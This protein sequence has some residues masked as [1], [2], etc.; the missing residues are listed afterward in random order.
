[1]SSYIQIPFGYRKKSNPLQFTSPKFNYENKL[2][3][4]VGYIK[5]VDDPKIKNNLLNA[6]KSRED[7]QKYILANSDVG[8]D[9]QEDINAITS[10]DEKFNNAAVRRALDLKNNDLFRNPQPITLL[11]HD[12]ER[13]HQ[14]NPI[15]GKLATQINVPKLSNRDEIRKKLLEGDIRQIE[16][17]L[18]NLRNDNNTNNF[19]IGGDNNNN[20]GGVNRGGDDDSDDSDGDDPPPPASG[21]RIGAL[22]EKI[23]VVDPAFKK[24]EPERN[25]QDTF[26][27]LRFGRPIPKPR[28]E[29]PP[30]D[31]F[32][33][34]FWHKVS[35]DPRD[36]M[37][38]K[39]EDETV[40]EKE[41][42]ET[43]LPPPP[44]FEPTKKVS[45]DPMTKTL[46]GERIQ[47][48]HPTE[49]ISEERQIS[50]KIQ[51][52]FPDIGEINKNEKKADVIVEYENLSETLGSI[53]PTE[54]I[55]FDFEFFKGGS[56]PRFEEI[57][58]NFAD[59]NEDITEFINFLQGDICRNILENNKLTI[60]VDSGKIF[61]EN[62]DTNESIFNFI[63][64]QNNPISGYIG[65]NI[66]FDHDYKT[67]FQWVA[68]AFSESEK[69]KL[70]ILTNVN[71]K[72]LFY[73]FNDFLQQKS[74]K[75]K[76][77]KHS[78]VTKD[79][80]AGEKIQDTSWKYFVESILR[81]AEKP[82]SN[83]SDTEQSF[84]IDTKEN[85]E[86]LKKTYDELFRQIEKNH[87]EM[88]E[89][90]PF[91]F[92]KDIENDLRRELYVEEDFLKL[93]TWISFYYRFGR[94]P[95]E[96]ELT[97]L[98]QSQKPKT[99]N[100][101]S[102]EFSPL[103]LYKEFG[104]KSSKNIASF[105]AIVA[106]YLHHA[107]EALTAKRAM[108]EWKNN[109]TFQTLSAEND[110]DQIKFEK[111][112]KMMLHLFEEFEK[113]K[114]YFIEYEKIQLKKTEKTKA[115]KIRT[116]TPIKFYK[117]PKITVNSTPQDESAFIK[118]ALTLENTNINATIEKEEEDNRETIQ[119]IIDPTP[120]SILTQ[121]AP[122]HIL[123]SREQ[124]ESKFKLGNSAQK[125]LDN[126]LDN[127]FQDIKLPSPSKEEVFKIKTEG[128][129]E[130]EKIT[131]EINI[132]KQPE[133][134]SVISRPKRKL[135][136]TSPYNL[137]QRKSKFLKSEKALTES[138]D[139]SVDDNEVKKI[140]RAGK[141]IDSVINRS[142]KVRQEFVFDENNNIV[143]E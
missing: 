4:E 134:T 66:S 7:L 73:R 2:L 87:I 12:I 119:S 11:F 128:G 22:R 80:I 140:D 112:S 6:I 33:P 55:P 95:G 53:E 57:L 78:V 47:I 18:F 48:H 38:A 142:G 21:S 102:T 25:L 72:F 65:R 3:E 17:R 67:Y 14:Q 45:F 81:Y 60:H 127:I 58:Q 39:M 10:G 44:L 124:D 77:I 29:R 68:S 136:R 79:Y 97:I 108:E 26:K 32:S 40:R 75:T 37:E 116:S 85:I 69:N 36:T 92:F 90:M 114:N 54:N 42:R 137:R 105:Q 46:D 120:G 118:T 51:K 143:I 27:H 1:M 130:I 23:A 123:E 61:Y 31:P 34:D 113:M 76:S 93:D 135:S 62:E 141:L 8:Y 43:D 9:L 13:F 98:P 63:L 49:E 121:S 84:V 82:N 16:N 64:A 59:N 109:L 74:K 96:Q 110:K 70:D 91:D 139:F 52:L 100:P 30:A 103:E 129:N 41:D 86:I 104:K 56:H 89:K 94:F 106:L 122:R 71:S 5:N 125:R 126:I 133:F 15:I 132:E 99:I 83:Y 115:L 101:L 24:K 111:L 50:E 117:R 19:P 88:L 107:G 35:N 28:P 131:T 138:I 20:S